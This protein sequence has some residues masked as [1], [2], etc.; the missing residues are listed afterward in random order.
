MSTLLNHIEDRGCHSELFGK[1]RGLSATSIV[2]C[3]KFRTVQK[4]DFSGIGIDRLIEQ[5][6]EA[7]IGL[8]TLR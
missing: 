5:A 7:A 6:V 2:G 3:L 1:V 8:D 4:A